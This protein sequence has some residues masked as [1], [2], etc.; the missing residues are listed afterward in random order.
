MKDK[1]PTKK[2]SK[3]KKKERAAKPEPKKEGNKWQEFLRRHDKET[4][5]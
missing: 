3:S 5:K 4:T 2:P 1:K